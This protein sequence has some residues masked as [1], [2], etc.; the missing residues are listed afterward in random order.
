MMDKDLKEPY[1]TYQIIR[2]NVRYYRNLINLN[3]TKMTQENLA[4]K[5]NLSISVIGSLESKNKIQGISIL[6]LINLSKALNVEP[7]DL[8]KKRKND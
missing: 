2:E 3:G 5:A 7:E 4:E 1:R 6:S 8:L